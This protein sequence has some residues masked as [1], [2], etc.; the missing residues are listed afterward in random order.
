VQE[1]GIFCGESNMDGGAASAQ[2]SS[3]TAAA[4]SG[5]A[6]PAM[7]GSNGA[8]GAAEPGTPARATTR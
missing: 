4:A 1:G 2:P 5:T 8:D 3:G 7:P 6:T